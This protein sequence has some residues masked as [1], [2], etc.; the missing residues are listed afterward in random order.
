MR[1]KLF[2]QSIIGVST[3]LILPSPLKLLAS[4]D[5]GG[6]GGRYSTRVTTEMSYNGTYSYGGTFNCFGSVLWPHGLTGTSIGN[7]DYADTL[8]SNFSTVGSGQAGDIV[9]YW[10]SW[11]E[12]TNPSTVYNGAIHAARITSGDS[13]Y[14]ANNYNGHYWGYNTITG[15]TP[16]STGWTVT[17]DSTTIHRK[18]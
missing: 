10:G 8:N 12:N 6:G 11:Y 4:D 14:S 2:L 15:Y 1:R 9:T 7:G 18:N 17:V 5:D 3:G 13:T 16:A